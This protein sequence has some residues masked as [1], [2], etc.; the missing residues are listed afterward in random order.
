MIRMLLALAV[1]WSAG[2]AQSRCAVPTNLPALVSGLEIGVNAA[3]RAE[4]LAPLRS[5]RRLAAAAHG[6][7]CDLSGS[8][9]RTHRGSDGRNS[10]QRV[11]RA[12]FATCLTAENLAWGFPS[13]GQIVR[14]WLGSAPHRRN[15]LLERTTHFGAG[16][17]DGPDGPIWVV[18]FAE[19]C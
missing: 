17:A 18:V 5:D 11:G 19:A 15:I 9:V 14:G 13:A 8:G 1:F 12:G 3:R 16:V 4:G 10:H 7:A 2:Q 6:H